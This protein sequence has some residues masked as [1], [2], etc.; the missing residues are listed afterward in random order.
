MGNLRRP[1]SKRWPSTLK[2]LVLN[3]LNSSIEELPNDL[4]ITIEPIASQICLHIE[5]SLVLSVGY[6]AHDKDKA[7]RL[8]FQ[9]FRGDGWSLYIY[10]D[11]SSYGD[12]SQQAI[13]DLAEGLIDS[14]LDGAGES[15]VHEFSHRPIESGLINGFLTGRV[16]SKDRWGPLRGE[17]HPEEYRFPL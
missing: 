7:Y 16:Q 10:L 5:Y 3:S 13:E 4:N 9:D 14:W 15:V 12:C 2:E 1:R 17:I 11:S 6:G 8:D